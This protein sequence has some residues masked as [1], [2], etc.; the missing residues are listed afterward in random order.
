[1]TALLLQR[2]LSMFLG[3]PLC[4]HAPMF[5]WLSGKWTVFKV[6]P[7]L[8]CTRGSTE[9]SARFILSRA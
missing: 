2:P 3:I 7:F 4:D 5:S 6:V 1:M 8:T 9:N